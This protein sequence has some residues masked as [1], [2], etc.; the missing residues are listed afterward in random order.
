[1]AKGG[2][3]TGA[4]DIGTLAKM[5]RKCGLALDFGSG[6]DRRKRPQNHVKSGFEALL[7]VVL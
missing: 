3:W 2:C 6:L 5:S 4:R 7:T 1:M